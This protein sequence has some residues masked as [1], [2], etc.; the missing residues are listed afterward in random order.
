MRYVVTYD[1][2]DHRL[3]L[4]V[5]NLLAGYG[6]RVQ[7]SVFECHLTESSLSQLL[8]RLTRLA[9]PGP[10]FNVRLYRVCRH[11]AGAS[12]VVGEDPARQDQDPCLIL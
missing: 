11:C 8:H 5:A 3:R 1:I 4:R 6:T 9:T 10:G 7:E 12:W 2:A